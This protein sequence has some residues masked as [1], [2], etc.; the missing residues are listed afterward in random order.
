MAAQS[1]SIS[2]VFSYPGRVVGLNVCW[3]QTAVFLVI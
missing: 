3:E 2:F 1:Y